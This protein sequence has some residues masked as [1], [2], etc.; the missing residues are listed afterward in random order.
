MIQAIK[1][2]PSYS[3]NEVS[4]TTWQVDET[5]DFVEEQLWNIF[6]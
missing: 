2:K 3:A 4:Y 5:L 1:D 6:Q